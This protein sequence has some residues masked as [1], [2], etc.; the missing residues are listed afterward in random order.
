[1]SRCNQ[2]VHTYVIR[3]LSK[4]HFQDPRSFEKV[5]VLFQLS[6]RTPLTHS[7]VKRYTMAEQ[8]ASARVW[9][10]VKLSPEADAKDPK[11]MSEA[12]KVGAIL[13]KTLSGDQYFPPNQGDITVKVIILKIN[14]G[15]RWGRICCGEAGMGWA[16][17]DVDWCLLRQDGKEVSPVKRE[18]VK[19]SGAL[20]TRDANQ[21]FSETQI[22]EDMASRAANQVGAKA[23]AAA[24][25]L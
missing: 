15:S 17:L 6:L 5:F 14:K 20:G 13:N 10:E 1:M 21:E 9:Y 16:S 22:V 3:P 24:L 7:S 11:K 12:Y 25:Q 4:S 18:R 2:T 23:K 19:D 8:T